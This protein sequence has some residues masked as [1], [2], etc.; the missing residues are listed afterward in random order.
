MGRALRSADW[1]AEREQIKA[2]TEQISESLGDNAAIDGIAEA[3]AD[4]WGELHKGT[5]YAKPS[6]SFTRNEI[7]SLLRHLSVGFSPGHGQSI[8]DR[9]FL[10]R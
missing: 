1:S 5:Y 10:S 7:E 2:L 4:R 3:L 6:V 9:F 8:P